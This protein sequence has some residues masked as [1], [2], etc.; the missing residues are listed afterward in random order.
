MARTFA[1]SMVLGRECLGIGDSACC[2]LVKETGV[3]GRK[4]P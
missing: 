2:S 1:S 3:S 4:L